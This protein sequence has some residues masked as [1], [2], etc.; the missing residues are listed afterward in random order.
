MTATYTILAVCTGNI[1]RSPAMERLLAHLLDDQPGIEVI[2]GG[3]YAHDG[4]DMQA[5][6]KRRLAD[7]GADTEDFVAEQVTPEMIQR[8]DLILAATRVHVEDMLAEVPQAQ[9]RMFTHP[10]FGRL[11]E[12]VTPEDLEAAVGAEAAAAQ[13][14]AALI[15]LLNQ[16]RGRAGSQ[17]RDEDVVDPYM[18]PESVFD[19]SF[20]QIREPIEALGELLILR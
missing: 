14:L 15:P 10:E 19:E 9:E 8:S 20:R 18:L 17:S 16:A 2:S 6:V 13:R 4:E 3:T 5:P 7:Y 1:C 11:L 12:S